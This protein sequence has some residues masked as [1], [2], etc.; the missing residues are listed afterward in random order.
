MHRIYSG[1]T[2][3]FLSVELVSL[4]GLWTPLFFISSNSF[5]KANFLAMDK[6]SPFWPT[7]CVS[8][9]L[10]AGS[11]GFLSTSKKKSNWNINAG[12]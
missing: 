9:E 10:A 7:L 8:R 12:C 11:P 2:L 6:Q 4:L 1:S 5:S 3:S